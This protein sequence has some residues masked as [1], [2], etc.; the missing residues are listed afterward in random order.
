[1]GRGSSSFLPFG[2]APAVPLAPAEA[3][4][5]SS[6][7]ET[8]SKNKSLPE[9]LMQTRQNP[10]E[11]LHKARTEMSEELKRKDGRT[12]GNKHHYFLPQKKGSKFD[13]QSQDSPKSDFSV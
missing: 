12:P 10:Q 9:N 8:P 4:E 11:N 2:R 1:M 7:G 3:P 6:F 13:I 5:V